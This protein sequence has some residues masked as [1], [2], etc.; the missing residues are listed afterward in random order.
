MT[1]LSSILVITVFR[2]RN[3]ILTMTL[4]AKTRQDQGFIYERSRKV[5]VLSPM[6]VPIA[7]TQSLQSLMPACEDVPKTST[8]PYMF[9]PFSLV[10]AARNIYP[11]KPL[12][13]AGNAFR[14]VEPSL[15][16][17]L[18]DRLCSAQRERYLPTT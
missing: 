11:S 1:K 5:S 10:D 14:I 17:Q 12:A 3:N 13:S 7:L 8:S 15:M 2:P 4:I 6:G 9:Q 16:Q 18:I